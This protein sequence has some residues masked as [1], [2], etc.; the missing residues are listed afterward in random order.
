MGNVLDVRVSCRSSE[1]AVAVDGP[2]IGDEIVHGRQQLANRAGPLGVAPDVVADIDLFAGLE[3]LGDLLGQLEERRVGFAPASTSSS[4]SIICRPPAGLS[5]GRR[6]DVARLHAGSLMPSASA[7]SA[8]LRRST[9]FIART[10]RSVR[11]QGRHG[12]HDLLR[13]CSWRTRR[14]LGLVS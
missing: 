14:L 12:L 6:R 3:P 9:Y 10:S 1:P 5:G 4:W 2:A 11:R 13:S 7:I 8:V